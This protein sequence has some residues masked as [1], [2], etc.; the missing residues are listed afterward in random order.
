[1]LL[2]INIMVE[3]TSQLPLLTTYQFRRLI[4]LNKIKIVGFETKKKKIDLTSVAGAVQFGCVLGGCWPNTIGAQK[5]NTMEIIVFI[6]R[7]LEESLGN[8]WAV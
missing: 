2:I 4:H 8:G 3:Y 7:L 6:V 5:R 1:M